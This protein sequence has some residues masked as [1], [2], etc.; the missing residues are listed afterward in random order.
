MQTSPI[1][2]PLQGLYFIL[3]QRWASTRSLV[4]VLKQASEAGVMLVQYRDKQG[5]LRETYQHAVTLRDAAGKLGVT[6]IVNDRCDLAKAVEADGVHLGQSDLPV[7]AARELLG[8]EC[9]IGISTHRDEE[10]KSATMGGADYL[11]FGPIYG[12][13]TKKD[14][15]PLVG[16][17]GLQRVRSFTTLPIFAIGGITSC[18]VP[19]LIAAGADGVAVASAILDSTDIK[20][21]VE[22]FIAAFA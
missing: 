21:T 3:D 15:E 13:T 4:D 6:F 22:Q 17:E 20:F 14:H 11:G 2:T 19:N 5:P 1:R 12:T 18:S 10:V 16:L 9:L 7:G 8:P